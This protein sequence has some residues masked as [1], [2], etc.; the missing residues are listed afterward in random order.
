VA[1][2][3][4]APTKGAITKSFFPTAG[5]RPTQRLQMNIKLSTIATGHGTLR[6]FYH[7]FNIMDDPTCVCKKGP[8]TSDRLLWECEMLRKQ[9]EVL[10]NRIKKAGGNWPMTNS[11]VA[12]K[13]SKLFH[14][15]VKAINFETLQQK[16]R[17][18][19]CVAVG[20]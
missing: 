16:S 20:I 12:T 3:M 1:K 10:K 19:I 2:R 5:G 11:D 15:F 8:Q 7:R 9:R 13:H 6:S 17:T 4:D 14:I 18:L